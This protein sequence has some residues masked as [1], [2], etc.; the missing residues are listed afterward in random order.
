MNKYKM[1]N[2]ESKSFEQFYVL[3]NIEDFKFSIK[4]YL[5]EYT[6]SNYTDKYGLV[7]NILY[8][9]MNDFINNIKI[10]TDN[11]IILKDNYIYIVKN[12]ELNFENIKYSY[13]EPVKNA[14]IN[15]INNFLKIQNI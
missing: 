14:F 11:K 1:N 2:N 3:T 8:N 13:P 10:I 5:I 4:N 6:N 12:C 15:T 7:F 9:E